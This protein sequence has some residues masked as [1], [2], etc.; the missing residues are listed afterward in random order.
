MVDIDLE[1]YFD[2]VNHDILINKIREKVSDERIINLIR[3]YLKSGI[4][5]N[6]IIRHRV[7]SGTG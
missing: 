3:K 4:L 2:T 7:Q 6:G 1:K 5:K